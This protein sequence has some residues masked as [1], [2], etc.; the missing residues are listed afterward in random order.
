MKTLNKISNKY[1]VLLISILPL[2]VSCDEIEVD[3]TVDEILSAQPTIVSFEPTSTPVKG[4]VT[5]TGTYLNFVNKAYIGEQECNIYRKVNSE[6]LVIEVAANAKSGSIKLTTKAEKEVIANSQLSVTY[7]EPSITS[8]I[9]SEKL[10][11]E[12]II[13]EGKNL[14]VVSKVSF[15][16]NEGIIEFQEETAL[17]VKVPY[18]RDAN[19]DMSI[20]YFNGTAPSKQVV[21]AGF[22]ILIPQP[23]ISTWPT[24]LKKGLGVSISGNN[25]NL[26]ESVTLGDTK[27]TEFVATAESLT[28][29]IP[30]AVTTNFYEIKLGYDEGN[31]IVKSSNIPYIAVAYQ[32][33]FDWNYSDIGYVEDNNKGYLSLLQV[34]GT[35]AQP[36]FPSGSSYA[37][38]I[39]DTGSSES[40]S[41]VAKLR[42]SKS[43]NDTW[44]ALGE[45]F[46]DPVI[47]FWI[48]TNNTT[49]TIQIELL[50]STKVSYKAINTGADWQLMA[51]RL[52]D[53][54]G[55]SAESTDGYFRFN[56]Q[57][58]KQT[59]ACELNLDWIIISDGVLDGVGAIDVTDKFK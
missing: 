23:E 17:V 19:N 41:T 29:S 33:F 57:S 51:V 15:G 1:W 36:S 40:S 55:D 10:V 8:E 50:K 54:F 47:H 18:S 3:K 45:N 49:P 59:V 16:E 4:H 44:K 21:K 37:H 58:Y 42:F 27:I 2:L 30:D 35:V 28:F 39:M 26:V 11:N 32:E 52:S 7:P 20:E 46:S 6:E 14:N 53:I 13:I 24:M 56:L 5:V 31:G 38:I 22:T 34:N 43:D 9:P 25:M 12:T 48:N